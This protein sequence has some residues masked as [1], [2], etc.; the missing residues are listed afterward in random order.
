[1]QNLVTLLL[2]ILSYCRKTT[3]GQNDPHQAAMGNGTAT[4]AT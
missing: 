3:G 4:E 1:M 2:F